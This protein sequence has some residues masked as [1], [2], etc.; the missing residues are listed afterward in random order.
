V[1]VIR[2]A[3]ST[4]ST[5]LSGIGTLTINGT[6]RIEA[7]EKHTLAVGDEIRLWPATTKLSGTPKF[8]MQGGVT[9]DTSRISEGVLVVKE[10]TET[11]GVI[12]ALADAD[13][14]NVYDLRG[15]LVSRQTTATGTDGLPAGIYIR[16]GRKVV[17]K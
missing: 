14:C 16:G 4:S 1:L 11:T 13:A 8:D 5:A 12:A 3:S 2:A 15:R 7:A 9:W 10:V 6:I 17:V